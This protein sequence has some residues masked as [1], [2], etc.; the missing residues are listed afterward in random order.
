MR[1]KDTSSAPSSPLEDLTTAYR[2]LTPAR[3]GQE[4]DTQ[5]PGEQVNKPSRKT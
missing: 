1:E 3:I 4:P 2:T 5:T